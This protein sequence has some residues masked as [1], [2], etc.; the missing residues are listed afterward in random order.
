ME[1]RLAAILIADVVGFSRLMGK[2]ETG[3]L[4]AV[5]ELWE[6][7]L[8]PKVAEQHGRIVKLMGD[9]ALVEFSSVVDA[10]EC[11]VSVQRDSADRNVEVPADRRIEMRI[12]INLGDVIIEGDGICGDVDNCP[13]D[14]N[15]GQEDEDGDD[16]GDL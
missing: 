12:G 10:V 15:P 1:R 9:G 16:A 3:T 5:K 14:F 2:D 6:V 11:A 7:Q 4:I 8:G 13:N